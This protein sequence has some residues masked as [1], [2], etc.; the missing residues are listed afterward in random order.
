MRKKPISACVATFGA[1]IVFLGAS[2]IAWGAPPPELEAVEEVLTHIINADANRAA[3][4]NAAVAAA[5]ATPEKSVVREKEKASLSLQEA[6]AEISREHNALISQT[7]QFKVS[8]E[9]QGLVRMSRRGDSS[10]FEMNL[11][12][13]T[14]S[15]VVSATQAK[16]SA[17]GSALFQNYL[18]DTHL[19]IQAY[20]DSVR[21]L[22]VLTS[23]AAPVE[24]TYPV[25]LPPNG[26]IERDENGAVLV[27][28]QAG[29]L[30]GAFSVPW[31]I[32]SEGKKIPTR[33]EVRGNAV[34]QVV[35]HLRSDTRYP[36]VADPWMWIDLIKSA[37]WKYNRPYGW[38]L[39]VKPT[40]WARANAGSYLVGVYGWDELYGKYKNRGLNTNLGGM[41]D[42][43]ICH[44]DLMV[45]ALKS[46]WNLDEWRPDV[47]YAQTKLALC[48]PGRP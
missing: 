42:Q 17:D 44:Q 35:E 15:S 18:H 37:S 14:A 1:A 25:N 20:E 8:V 38:T 24:F 46:S 43:F 4:A 2:T 11:P 48:N 30:V 39:Q 32:D 22:T 10:K 7:K 13:T 33:Y 41:R 27:L 34:V 31:A 45:A 16:I 21:V 28:D 6:R 26:K 3:A 36:V 40:A 19:A 9:G 12:K 5:G 23:N 29:K 47:S